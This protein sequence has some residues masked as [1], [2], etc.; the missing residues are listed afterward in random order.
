ML[1]T[2]ST[3]TRTFKKPFI[4]VPATPTATAAMSRASTQSEAT[5]RP[6][7]GSVP[8]R[9]GSRFQLGRATRS[10][11]LTSTSWDRPPLGSR[12]SHGWPNHGRHNVRSSRD[13]G[14]S[15]APE[16]LQSGGCSTARSSRCRGP[17]QSS[18]NPTS[19]RPSRRHA[20]PAYTRPR[21]SGT[22][23]PPPAPGSWKCPRTRAH[24]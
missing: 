18:C 23:P 22:A 15:L 2:A 4:S 14:L 19:T 3:A 20:M 8:R 1:T 5:P 7:L 21:S 17:Q 6:R 9:Q 24:S 10:S 11:A 16:S 13:E 12:W